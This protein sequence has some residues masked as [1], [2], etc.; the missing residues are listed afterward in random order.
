MKTQ[1][2]CLCLTAITCGCSRM[3][4]DRPQESAAQSANDPPVDRIANRLFFVPG[5][6]AYY[7][8]HGLKI[9]GTRHVVSNADLEL[10]S[11]TPGLRK[12]L[13]HLV[14]VEP[15]ALAHLSRCEDL[16][17]LILQST[18]VTDE[19][20]SHLR[21]HRKL[22]VLN[23]MG[24]RVTD[25]SYRT[26]ATLPSLERL[27]IRS[28]SITRGAAE[29]IRAALPKLEYLDLLDL[30]SRDEV[31]QRDKTDDCEGPAN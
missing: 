9:D 25:E 20:F 31:P 16:E 14:T 5:E 27:H 2:L 29:R 6:M 11:R 23:L 18:D 7:A 12:V 8:Q 10:V 13:L 21:G 3:E 30:S 17:E 1:L 15:G 28:T 26:I 4:S 24:T 19:D 22:R